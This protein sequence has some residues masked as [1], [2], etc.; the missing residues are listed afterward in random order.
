MPARTK[1]SVRSAW[2]LALMGLFGLTAAYVDH[3][4]RE[5][6]ISL[7]ATDIQAAASQ[8]A[9]NHRFTPADC[10]IDLPPGDF[11]LLAAALAAVEQL[12]TGR[13][14]IA[15]EAAIVRLAIVTGLGAPD[16]SLGPG[17]I[18]PSTV[19]A[20]LLS[21]DNSLSIG[22][23]AH[24]RQQIAHDL[25]QDCKGHQLSVLVLTS[26]SKPKKAETN[27]LNREDIMRIAGAYNAQLTTPSHEAALA[28]YLYRELTY[29]VFL[30]LKFQAL[31]AASA[32]Q[33]VNIQE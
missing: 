17:Q 2:A 23:R 13:V 4:E 30:E 9:K 27:A 25:L 6:V 31:L 32:D 12:A 15:A 19:E 33:T 18:R 5:S 20:A 24:S 21:A 22:N 26:L 8:L 10:G 11:D 1:W 28:H 29:Q 16:F 7:A 14:E 3:A